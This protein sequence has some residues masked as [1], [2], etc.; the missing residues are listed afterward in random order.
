M[1]YIN[2]FPMRPLRLYGEKYP[3]IALLLGGDLFDTTKSHPVSTVYRVFRCPAAGDS[4]KG[5][6]T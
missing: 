1:N 5:G 4:N 3:L 6:G 2:I